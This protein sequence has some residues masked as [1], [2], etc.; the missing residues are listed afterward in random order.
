MNILT[1][2]S[3][4]TKKQITSSTK[5][6][7]SYC[8]YLTKV[9]QKNTFTEPES[10]INLPFSKEA[11]YV[12]TMSKKVSSKELK[13]IIFIGIGGS[14]LGT[15]AV[16][17]ALSKS[18]GIKKMY[19]L[20]TVSGP[21]F[22][23]VTNELIKHHT[24]KNQFLIIVVSK[25]G[26][27]IE[28]VANMEALLFSLKKSYG[29][30]TDRMVII[31]NEDSQLW[32][33]SVEQKINHLAIP[34]M[35][36]GRFSVFSA[37]GL[38][39]LTLVGINIK[40]LLSGAQSAVK[41]GLLIDQNKNHALASALMT[42]KQSIQGKTIHNSFFF[43]PELESLGK[44]YRQLMGESLGKEKNTDGKIIH[45]G[46]TPIVSI[47]STDLHSMAQLYFGGP[48]DKFTNLISVRKTARVT[49]PHKCLF[50]KLVEQ[51]EAKTFDELMQ[52]I[53]DGVA[54]TYKKSNHPFLSIEFERIDEK[55]LG[56]F[57]QFRMLE[58]M[59]LAHLMRI[60]AFDQPNVE[61]YKKE[62]QKFL[63]M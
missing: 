27:T 6:L 52:A 53:V 32:K 28:T 54:A 10:S 34:K 45:A 43:A 62:T 51:L 40:N 13:T 56:Y 11:N 5:R 47:G 12:L 44:W 57:M 17:D 26:G 50:P 33:Q 8:Q 14:N 49:V 42:H 22:L 25:S 37:V 38:F 35:V 23:S 24:H 41:N 31:T 58:I 7:E 9:H 30:V 20:E 36:G 59:Y 63:R 15:K 16:Y 18:K 4:V 29:D 61:G 2:N 48:N 39:P 46:I 1:N 3:T 21:E 60:N 55:E 19:F